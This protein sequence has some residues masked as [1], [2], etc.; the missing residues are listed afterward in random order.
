MKRAK[1]LFASLFLL[2]VLLLAGVLVYSWYQSKFS[3]PRKEAPIVQFKIS[4]QNTLI[5]VLSNLSYYGFIKDENAFKYALQNTKDNT[6]GKEGVIKIGNNTIDTESAYNISQA[7]SAWEI[8]KILLN[9]GTPTSTDCSDGCPNKTPF[10]PELLPGGNIAP[11]IQERLRTEYDWV[12]NYDDCIKAH[13]QLS[14]E[15]YTERTGKP[16]ECVNPDSRVFTQGQEGWSDHP[17]P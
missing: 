11:S 14:S 2:A 13:G 6:P 5:A 3:A 12:K 4:K 16:R 17:S 7:M 1:V 8:A 9:E 10:E 15:Q